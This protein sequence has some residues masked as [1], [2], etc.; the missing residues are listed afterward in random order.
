MFS[1]EKDEGMSQTPVLCG[2]PLCTI[3]ANGKQDSKNGLTLNLKIMEKDTIDLFAQF[4]EERLQ[5]HRSELNTR[6]ENERLGSEQLRSDAYRDHQKIF[7]E[8]LNEKI[9]SLMQNEN[10]PWLKGE[11]ENLRHKYT[12]RFS[13]RS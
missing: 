1:K 7:E 9:K 3:I 10:N 8:E 12:G 13:D 11:L 5:N 2:A 6:Y 4:A